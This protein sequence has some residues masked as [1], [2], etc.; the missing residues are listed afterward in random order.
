MNTFVPIL[1]T[2]VVLGSIFAACSV[3]LALLYGT[4]RFLNLAHGGFLVIGG[5][6]AWY[7][8]SKLGMPFAVGFLVAGVVGMGVGLFTY[9]VILRPLLGIGS[10]RWDIATII[11]SVGMAIV[12]EAL[13]LQIFGPRLKSLPAAVDGAFAVGVTVIRYNA[14]FVGLLAIAILIVTNWFLKNTRNG[15][16]LRAVASDINTANLIGIPGRKIFAVTVA[17]SSALT[18]TA[19]VL[20]GSFLFSSPRQRAKPDADRYC[21][22]CFWRSG[23]HQ[24]RYCGSLYYWFCPGGSISAIWREM[25]NASSLLIHDHH[26]DFQT[27]RP[28]WQ[29]RRSQDLMTTPL[30]RFGIVIVLVAVLIAIGMPWI[31]PAYFL[32][33]FILF[34]VWAMVAQGWNL[35]WGIAGVWSLGQMAIFAMAGYCTGWIVIHTGIST[36]LAAVIGVLISLVASVVM[37]I[38]SIRLKGVYV[39]LFTISFHELFRTLLMT[40]TSGFT[41]GQFG[42]PSYAGFVSK[43]IPFSERTRIYYYIALILFIFVTAGMAILLRIP[44]GVSFQGH[45]SGP[46]ICR[47]PWNQLVQDADPRVFDRRTIRRS[48]RIILGGLLR[49]HAAWDTQLRYPGASSRDDGNWRLGDFFWP[50]TGRFAPDLG[51]RGPS[52][53]T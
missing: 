29:T 14:L 23:Q 22:R 32:T 35:V 38:P 7:V 43:E 8:T 44:S 49:H 51:F 18:T 10:P 21:C 15:I 6:V 47:Q 40:D 52:P 30:P 5:Y 33:T 48:G 41:G 46:L 19:G 25:G 11:A 53:S 24:R 16:A 45:R 39:I 20:L 2:G 26:V 4:L 12:I 27:I 36:G 37:S 13:V 31:V 28:L 17:V 1:Y 42:L 3:G 34:F 9:I 50:Y